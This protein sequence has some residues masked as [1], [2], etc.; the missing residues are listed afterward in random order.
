MYVHTYYVTKDQS[1]KTREP[2]YEKQDLNVVQ[3]EILCTRS[4]LEEP[5][6]RLW[7]ANNEGSGESA[8][9]RSFAGAFAVRVSSK[10]ESKI[11]ALFRDTSSAT[12]VNIY[13]CEV[14]SNNTQNESE[15]FW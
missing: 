8:R 10:F 11:I 13:T 3:Y 5:E 15:E 1:A 9:M 7:Y 4:N 12:I 14:S 2:S 6:L